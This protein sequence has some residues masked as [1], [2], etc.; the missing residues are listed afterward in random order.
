MHA[1]SIEIKLRLNSCR[2]RRQP[3]HLHSGPCSVFKWR[4]KSAEGVSGI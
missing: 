1:C 2:I 3:L 4:G